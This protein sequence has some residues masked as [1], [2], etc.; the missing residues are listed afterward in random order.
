MRTLRR[1]TTLFLIAFLLFSGT[2]F[3]AG[4]DGDG[5]GI[6]DATDNCPAVANPN[7]A[8]RNANAVGDACDDPDKDTLSD[9]YELYAT[10]G[11]GPSFRRTN[12][13]KKDTDTDGLSDGYEVNRTWSNGRH[14]DPTL[15]DTDGDGWEDGTEIYANTDP[16]DNDTDDDGVR[17]SI[18]N[19]ATTSNPDQK[20]IDRDGRG[21]ACDDPPPC[22]GTNCTTDPVAKQIED[23]AGN[24]PGTVTGAVNEVIRQLPSIDVRPYGDANKMAS[25]GYIV[26]IVQQ[27]SDSFQVQ[28]LNATT[29]Q[30][31]AL[32]VPLSKFWQVNG[33]VVAMAYDADDTLTEGT[34][35]NVKWLYNVRSKRLS[36]RVL[37][38]QSHF[39]PVTFAV[40]P[41]GYPAGECRSTALPQAPNTCDGFA[42]GYYNVAKSLQNLDALDALP[43]P[44]TVQAS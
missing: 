36:I 41:V 39:G 23:A 19:C 9:Q 37:K 12:P 38:K 32:N 28:V 10:Y 2:S 35:I 29:A 27:A 7:Q 44:I 8:D 5:D 15:R 3:G 13:D 43:Y 17:D 11:P 33:P 18:D 20:D 31:V 22:S 14:T 21:D 26:S 40:S 6:P 16:T 1:F 24:V 4:G 30:P 25:D 42:V 34:R